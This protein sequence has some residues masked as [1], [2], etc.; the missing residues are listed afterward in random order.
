[1][2]RVN[3]NERFV[4]KN[5]IKWLYICVTMIGQVV[6]SCLNRNSHI[7]I[8]IDRSIYEKKNRNIWLESRNIVLLVYIQIWTSNDVWWGNMQV[9][10]TLIRVLAIFT[11]FINKQPMG[12]NCSTYFKNGFL[13]PFFCQHFISSDIPSSNVD[14]KQTIS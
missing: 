3:E 9:S 7:F 10:H 13:A 11:K 14:F 12:C 5:G 6:L 2:E 1:M 8:L 4:V